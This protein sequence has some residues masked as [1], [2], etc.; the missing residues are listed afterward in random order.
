[1]TTFT[2]L[3]CPVDFS[4]SSAHALE[5]AAAMAGWY[6]AHLIALHVVS[7][8]VAVPGR[9]T[10]IDGGFPDA[11]R[12]CVHKE[13]TAFVQSVLGHDTT[14]DV[15]LA[16][17]H[18]AATILERTANLRA[19][20]VVMGTHGASGFERLVIGSVTEKVLRRATCPVL[21]V[22]PRAHATSMLPFR[23]VLCAVDFSDWSLAAVNLAASLAQGAGATLDLLHVIEW[24][25]NEP[26]APD[27]AALPAEQA[28]ALSEFRRYLAASACNRLGSLVANS[29]GRRRAVSTRTSHGKPYVE[30][31]KA[32][33]STAAD[34]IVLGVH[35]RKTLDMAIF[36][37]TTNHVIR[38]ATC[39][40]LTLRR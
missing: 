30:I 34:L 32:A 23:R 6:Q 20:L 27:L 12:E 14:V 9:V 1:V 18:P 37:S 36:G 7:P 22:P 3:L 33:A 26:P 10:P 28:A 38:A 17:G 19:D 25:W 31:L 8:V 5:H 13:A 16:A 21:T 15:Q 2:R 24:P 35:S 39:P 29:V 4:A 40:V 11:E